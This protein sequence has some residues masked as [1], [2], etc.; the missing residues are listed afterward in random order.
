MS[1][2]TKEKIV[3][4]SLPVT[5]TCVD[6]FGPFYVT[7]LLLKRCDS[8]SLFL[9]LAPLMLKW[10][11]PWRPVLVFWGLSSSCHVR[12]HLPWFGWTMTLNLLERRKNSGEVLKSVISALLKL[13]GLT[14]LKMKIET[15][16]KPH[17][18]RI[19]EIMVRRFNRLL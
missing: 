19:W 18:G 8:S 14:K 15:P 17:K 16:S 2:L 10:L 3:Y 6:Y 7:A 13:S 5:N 12:V 4:Q 9:L 11:L 1:Y